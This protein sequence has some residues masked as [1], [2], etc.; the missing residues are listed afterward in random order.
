MK[1]INHFS[2]KNFYFDN[3][4]KF[5]LFKLDVNISDFPSIGTYIVRDIDIDKPWFISNI[6]YGQSYLWWFIMA[7]NNIK[8]HDKDLYAG[9]ELKYPDISVYNNLKSRYQK[10]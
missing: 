2:R 9:M 4:G 5:N 3:K 7:Y 8:S 1:K 10:I 6:I